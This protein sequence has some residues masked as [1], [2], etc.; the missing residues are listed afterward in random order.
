MRN[1][2]PGVFGIHGR[3][4]L[5]TPFNIYLITIEDKHVN[6]SRIKLPLCLASQILSYLGNS[7]KEIILT[8]LV[9]WVGGLNDVCVRQCI[10]MSVLVNCVLASICL[11]RR[12]HVSYQNSLAV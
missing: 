10:W 9:S 11:C 3:V 12:V 8:G 2:E 4:Y 6:C 1:L 7:R 5:I